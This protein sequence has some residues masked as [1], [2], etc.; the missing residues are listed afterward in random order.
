MSLFD[1]LLDLAT[2]QLLLDELLLC[3]SRFRSLMVVATVEA[4]DDGGR[5]RKMVTVA[6]A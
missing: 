3:L 4:R 2:T 5:G 6:T 1:E